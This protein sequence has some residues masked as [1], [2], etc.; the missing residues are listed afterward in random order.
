MIAGIKKSDGFLIPDFDS[1]KGFL[2]IKNGNT[3][4][5]GIVVYTGVELD[6]GSI[7]N[8]IDKFGILNSPWIRKI[9]FFDEYLHH[10]KN[11]KIS[12]K[13]SLEIV[14]NDLKFIEK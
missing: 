11:L 2:S 6:G 10:V 1:G 12:K 5:V 4:Q 3:F 8:K 9:E 14:E 7:I 13:Y